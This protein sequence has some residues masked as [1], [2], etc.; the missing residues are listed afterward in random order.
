MKNFSLI[1]ILFLIVQCG[2]K[3]L[4]STHKVSY[5]IKSL[6]I[7]TNN[8]I[9]K[10]RLINEKTINPEYFYDLRINTSEN[11][12]ILSK[13]SL[14][15]TINYRMKVILNLEVIESGELIMKKNYENSFD[16]RNLDKKFELKSYE[17]E[18]KNDI[19]NEIANKIL[20]DL[21][22]LK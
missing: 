9:L 16:Y 21:T 12:S 18:I 2:Y 3:P 22:K 13:N 11:K 19:Y 6:D 1:L 20:L 4:L 8:N 15:K 14:G 5:E 17:N 10:S 7:N